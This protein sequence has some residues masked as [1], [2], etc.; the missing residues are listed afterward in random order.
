MGGKTKL[1]KYNDEVQVTTEICASDYLL[2]LELQVNPESNFL[3][4]Y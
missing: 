4:L 3:N 2:R 1:G